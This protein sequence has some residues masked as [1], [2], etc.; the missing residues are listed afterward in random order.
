MIEKIKEN[1]ALIAAC[2][3]GDT[4]ELQNLLDEK[5]LLIQ[6]LEEEIKNKNFVIQNLNLK[7]QKRDEL[8]LKCCEESGSL[9]LNCF[10]ELEGKQFARTIGESIIK[11]I[12]S[13]NDEK[14]NETEE[15]MNKTEEENIKSELFALSLDFLDRVKLKD[16]NLKI[17]LGKYSPNRNE[18]I[19]KDRSQIESGIQSGT[20]YF[21]NE[22]SSDQYYVRSIVNGEI[23][24]SNTKNNLLRIQYHDSIYF[25]INNDMVYMN[26]KNINNISDLK[27]YRLEKYAPDYTP[28]TIREILNFIVSYCIKS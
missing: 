16:S 1:E 3:N 23:T 12:D 28:N 9:L 21:T 13:T 15:E 8:L 6:G 2:E 25:S 18:N 20:I 4:I 11:D 10:G 14:M 24:F 19:P 26:F 17:L 22:N 27:K 5:N 7:I